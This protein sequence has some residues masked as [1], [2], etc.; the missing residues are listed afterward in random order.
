MSF[1]FQVLELTGQL[2]QSFN[3]S[4]TGYW[5]IQLATTNQASSLKPWYLAV[6]QGR[7][8]FSGTQ[9]LSWA[10]FVET[11]QRYVFRLRNSQSK[12]KLNLL[13][14]DLSSG[15]ATLLS[16]ILIEM[17][18]MNLLSHNE[19]LQALRLKVL[20][21]LDTYLFDYPGQAQFTLDY[22]LVTSTPIRG[23]E[24]NG[25]LLDAAKRRAQ[26]N[27]LRSHVPSIDSILMLK[28]EAVEGSDLT[29]V[30]RQQLQRLVQQGRT[31]DAIAY[32]MGADPLEA[33]KA[34]ASLIQKGL[35]T[36]IK[37]EADEAKVDSQ[38]PEIF[39]VDDSPVLVKQFLNLVVSWGYRVSYSNN[40]LTAVPTMLESE[41]LV[42]FLDINMPGASGFELIKQIRRQ[43]KLSSIPLVLL[44]AEKAASNQWRAQ[45]ANCK[46]LAKPS[47]PEEIPQF[48][49]ELR[50]M[51]REMAP[52]DKNAL[53]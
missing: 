33:A 43:P 10:S 11:L 8:V 40:A 22:K 28:P 37:S 15:E 19:A 16:K 50:T 53:V 17:E 34:F 36:V 23:F 5:Q 29:T 45:W 44:T 18:K 42:I 52:T 2:K 48:R 39:I 3:E 1:S 31:L 4:L 13:K 6:V 41:P 9:Q 27:Q 35:V 38:L 47:K 26:W 7:V 21:D 20:S 12:Q 14:Q 30:K 49:T 51:L 25:L 46:F 24:L 32:D